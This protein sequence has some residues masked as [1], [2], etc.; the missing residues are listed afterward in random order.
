KVDTTV[1]T[2][3]GFSRS[4]IGRE[5][6]LVGQIFSYKKGQSEGPLTGNYGAYYLTVDEV[7]EAPAKED[8][9]F[10]K[11]Q[12]LQS[13]SQRVTTSLFKAIEKTAKITD[14]R[15]RFY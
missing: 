1:L 7:N 4:A 5:M 15:I 12:L 9:T 14:N 10:E 11:S 13:F 6:E 8:F 2:F 3:A